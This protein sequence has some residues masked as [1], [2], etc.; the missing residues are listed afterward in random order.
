MLTAVRKFAPLLLES[1]A[2]PCSRDPKQSC[3]M[4][5]TLVLDSELEDFG[6]RDLQHRLEGTLM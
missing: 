6:A 5:W 4:K 3:D 2:A 1:L